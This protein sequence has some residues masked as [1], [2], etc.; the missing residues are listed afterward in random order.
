MVLATNGPR[1]VAHAPNRNVSDSERAVS[2]AVGGLLVASAVK[3]RGLG[4]LTLA[5][6]G[7]ELLRRGATGHC[8]L[9]EAIGFSGTG[10]EHGYDDTDEAGDVRS[11]T[12]RSDVRGAAAT[13]NARKSIKI[14]R[15]IT[16]AKPAAELYDFW[17]NFQNLP[18]V[19]DHL[20]SVSD[21]GNG[22][23]HWVA[24]GPNA[25]RVEWDSEIVNEIPGELIAWKTVGRPDVA[26]AGSVHFTPT[27]DGRSTVVRWV[28]DYEP[29]GGRFSA[30]A[31]RIIGESPDQKIRSDLERLKILF[32]TGEV[33][34]T[35]GQTSG[36]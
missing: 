10:H 20:E 32:E 27:A 3:K 34:T 31:A 36:R 30:M 23:S 8:M 13:V 2:A 35:E 21:L 16:I 22:R 17:R 9:Y 24:L 15:S 5:L 6:I 14:E 26:H 25:S 33:A 19:L 29:P 28:M 7:A 12:H 1:R 18:R 4:G 11:L